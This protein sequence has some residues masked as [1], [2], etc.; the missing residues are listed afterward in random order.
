[1][2]WKRISVASHSSHFNCS[3]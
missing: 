2:A 1:M 3:R